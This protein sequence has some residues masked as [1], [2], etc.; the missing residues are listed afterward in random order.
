[1]YMAYIS[2]LFADFEN[3]MAINMVNVIQQTHRTA[4]QSAKE[5]RVHDE[6]STYNSV[7]KACKYSIAYARC[8]MQYAYDLPMTWV[9]KAVNT[10]YPMSAA[11]T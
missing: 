9:K 1:M 5:S 8:K 4:T 6:Q 2:N 7:T 11:M 3:T 10:Q